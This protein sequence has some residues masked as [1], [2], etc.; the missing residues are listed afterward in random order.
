MPAALKILCAACAP[1][2]PDPL[3]IL[4]YLEKV[5]FIPADARRERIIPIISK[6]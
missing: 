3:R 5:L 2:R 4:L 6:K 1:V